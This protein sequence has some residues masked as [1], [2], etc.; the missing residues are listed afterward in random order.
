MALGV[1]ARIRPDS[2]GPDQILP[3]AANYLV[4]ARRYRAELR[5]VD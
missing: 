3:L 5:R 1:P 2:V 4:N